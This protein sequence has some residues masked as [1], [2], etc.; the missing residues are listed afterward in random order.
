MAANLSPARLFFAQLACQ[1]PAID[2]ACG[3]QKKNQPD[4]SDWFL[5]SGAKLKPSALFRDRDCCW[6]DLCVLRDH[7]LRLHSPQR[8]ALELLLL[9][10]ARHE[11]RDR[12]RCKRGA[13][14]WQYRPCRQLLLRRGDAL[15]LVQ[16]D[17]QLRDGR[18]TLLRE[19]RGRVWKLR[20][21]VRT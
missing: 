2:G 13:M 5:E 15:R 21:V 16:S 18:G 10:T 7:D 8:A 9:Q 20:G 17:G 3:T 12:R 6:N 1:H 4:F 11:G 19:V 14:R